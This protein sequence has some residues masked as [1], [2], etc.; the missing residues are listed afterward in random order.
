MTNSPVGLG[1]EG[2]VPT[3]AFLFTEAPRLKQAGGFL[4][5]APIF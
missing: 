3:I 2:A 5:F 4:F 1:E